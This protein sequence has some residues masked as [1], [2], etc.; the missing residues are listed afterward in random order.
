[1]TAVPTPPACVV[2]IT[3][4]EVVA[5]ALEVRSRLWHLA[6]ELCPGVR[7][8]AVV[9]GVGGRQAIIPGRPGADPPSDVVGRPPGELIERLRVIAR[10]YRDCAFPEADHGCVVLEYGPG[11]EPT[12]ID[13]G[14]AARPVP[15]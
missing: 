13:A 14:L 15:R 6:A 11:E 7:A 10:G 12:V 1:M 4:P 2:A 3:R 9:L 8:V 5:P